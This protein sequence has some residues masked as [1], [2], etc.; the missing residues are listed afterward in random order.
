M[1]DLKHAIRDFRD[2][3]SLDPSNVQ[4][5]NT[6]LFLVLEI[7]DASLFDRT[8]VKI[9]QADPET[10]TKWILALAASQM[11]TGTNEEALAL[12]K[13]AREILPP[14]QYQKL[15]ADRIFSGERSQNLI[16]TA[17]QGVSP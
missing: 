9:R 15:L 14:A 11:R 17:N 7:G 1:N 8:L 13:K 6:I 16:Q 5:S 10:E 3:L 4:T 2:A 12:L